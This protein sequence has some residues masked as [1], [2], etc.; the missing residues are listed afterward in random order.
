MLQNAAYL[1]ITNTQ[2]LWRYFDVD[3]YKLMHEIKQQEHHD[4]VEHVFEK[5]STGQDVPAA[6]STVSQNRM[7]DGRYSVC[8]CV[9]VCVYVCVHDRIGKEHLLPFCFGRFCCDL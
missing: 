5:L 1:D 2:L 9:Y 4:N 8:L 3:I 6:L 7:N